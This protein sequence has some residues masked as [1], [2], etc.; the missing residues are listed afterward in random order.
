MSRGVFP[1]DTTQ[2]S[3]F[4]L[5]IILSQNLPNKIDLSA[6]LFLH[7]EFSPFSQKF[8]NIFVSLYGIKRSLQRFGRSSSL[9]DTILSSVTVKQ[10]SFCGLFLMYDFI[11]CSEPHECYNFNLRR[12]PEVAI[13]DTDDFYV[14]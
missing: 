5:R 12:S 4:P 8:K 14:I 7:L 3:R 13:A 11:Q 10:V 1:V 6:F 2:I 9:T